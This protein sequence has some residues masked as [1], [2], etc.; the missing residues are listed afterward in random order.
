[1]KKQFDYSKER[2]VTITQDVIETALICANY[3]L[4]ELNSTLPEDHYP[5]LARNVR[6]TEVAI[7]FFKSLSILPK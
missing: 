4:S 6:D 1:M 7:K 5:D 2:T 3:M